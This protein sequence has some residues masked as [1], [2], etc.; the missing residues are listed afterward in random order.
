[1][2]TSAEGAAVWEEIEDAEAGEG[3]YLPAYAALL[4]DLARQRMRDAR[5]RPQPPRIPR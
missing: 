5:P 3:N 2:D 4:L 1:M